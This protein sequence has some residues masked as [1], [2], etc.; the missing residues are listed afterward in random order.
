MNKVGK[1]FLPWAFFNATYLAG[2]IYAEDEGM[3]VSIVSN[4]A[5]YIL[6]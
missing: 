6:N 3:S 1:R 4:G 5:D 2:I